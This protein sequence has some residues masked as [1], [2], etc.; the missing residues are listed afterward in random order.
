M[1]FCADVKD[2]EFI[3]GQNIQCNP[4]APPLKFIYYESAFVKQVIQ[5]MAKGYKPA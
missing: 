4:K 2:F 3:A 5:K 1:I